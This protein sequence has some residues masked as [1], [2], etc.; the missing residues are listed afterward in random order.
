MG[1]GLTCSPLPGGGGNI[2]GGNPPGGNPPGGN[3]TGNIGRDDVEFL[4][5]SPLYIPATL[6]FEGVAFSN[7]GMRLKGNSS[8]LSS[9]QS[10]VE[11][12]PFRLNAD[13]LE[14]TIPGAR[15]QTFFGFPNLNLTNNS[16]DASF[17]RAKVV[18]D[19]FREAGVAAARTAFVRVFFDRGQGRAI[20]QGCKRWSKCRRGRCRDRS[21]ENG[22][23]YEADGRAHD[24]PSSLRVV[25]EKTNQSDGEDDVQARLRY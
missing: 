17:L 24:D 14:D 3:P 19:L 15:D 4:P 9:W 10:G 20:P 5:R 6:T 2:P 23:L 25:S 8:L 7:V 11:K 1:T 12:L 16:Q 21:E 13:G 18:G 22:N